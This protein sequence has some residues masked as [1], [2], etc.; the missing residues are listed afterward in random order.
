MKTKKQK[1]KEAET[2]RQEQRDLPITNEGYA[3]REEF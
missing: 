1:A 3:E 2:W